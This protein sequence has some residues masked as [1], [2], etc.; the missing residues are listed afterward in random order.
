MHPRIA[1]MPIS[2]E[3]L[4]EPLRKS[5]EGALGRLVT[6][7]FTLL[8]VT[9][10][11]LMAALATTHRDLLVGR[12]FRLPIFD[13]EVGLIPFYMTAPVVLVGLLMLALQASASAAGSLSELR[14]ELQDDERR[15]RTARALSSFPLLDGLSDK[16]HRL[17]T[18]IPLFCAV[19]LLPSLALLLM[20]WTILPAQL[21]WL[22]LW[23]LIWM[24][25]AMVALWRLGPVSFT[26]RG[27]LEIDAGCR[28][29][30]RRGRHHHAGRPD[31]V[32]GKVELPPA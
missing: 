16:P 24:V 18:Q 6:A 30:S 8:S 2:S 7:V 25:G 23:Q 5:T 9:V 31:A 28:A 3:D 12:S 4:V 21:P 13:V 27:R 14:Q 10:Y 1:V 29:W 19:A 11:V 20:Q 17:R 32:P 22:A 15:R 26:D